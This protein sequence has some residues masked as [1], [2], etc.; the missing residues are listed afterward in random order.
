VLYF[1]KKMTRLTGLTMDEIFPPELA[2]K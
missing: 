2:N 1:F